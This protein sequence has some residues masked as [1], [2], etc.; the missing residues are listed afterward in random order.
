M[1]RFR[2]CSPLPE[3]PMNTPELRIMPPRLFAI[4]HVEW[5][6]S[7]VF[8][9]PKLTYVPAFPSSELVVPSIA[10]NLVG[11]P[12]AFNIV[13]QFVL[14]V[15]VPP[16]EPTVHLAERIIGIVGTTGVRSFPRLPAVFPCLCGA[17]PHPAGHKL[18]DLQR[19]LISRGWRGVTPEQL[20]LGVT[21]SALDFFG[22]DPSGG[23]DGN[24]GR[25]GVVVTTRTGGRVDE[26]LDF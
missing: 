12:L 3:N 8:G 1:R 20:A 24:P 16:H 7:G 5:C 21:E 11:R 22:V 15:H 23:G 19:A 18:D 9:A 4:D 17:L 6:T 14:S 13:W 2:W 26:H 10:I 25:D